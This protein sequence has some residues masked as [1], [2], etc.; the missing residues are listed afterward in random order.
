MSQP[1]V[2]YHADCNDGFG[3]AWAAWIRLGYEAEYRAV[4]YQESPPTTDEVAGRDVFI[5]DFS[6]SPMDIM[7]MACHAEHVVLL[8]HHKSAAEMF[9]DYTAPKHVTVH[10]DLSRS[11]AILAWRHFFPLTPPPPIL[12][13]VQDRDLWRWDLAGSREYNAA[14]TL[15]PREFQVWNEL[16]DR[17]VNELISDG[18]VVVRH[19]KILVE[20]VA[21]KAVTRRM[22]GHDVPIVNATQHHSELGHRLS[23]GVAFAAMWHVLPDG[24][25]K[26]S[27]RS[28]HGVEPQAV[29]VGAA[30]A[31]LGGGGHPGAAS[32]I[33]SM[34]DIESLLAGGNESLRDTV[35]WR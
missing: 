18:D 8:D 25:A 33:T 16:D 32:F 1:L 15:Y 31:K 35:G 24:R 23:G 5:L 12:Q 17:P 19:T 9:R 27:L 3:A 7:D 6:Y 20:D 26:V 30:A 11:G 22:F 14:L 34:S 2:L 28:N 13:F 29:D 4:R 21:R 10:F